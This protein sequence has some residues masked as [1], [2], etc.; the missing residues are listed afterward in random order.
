MT[1]SAEVQATQTAA[2]PTAKQLA[3]TTAAAVL[4]A[5]AI[6]VTIVL[7]AEYGL[8][9]LGTGDRLG[10]TVMSAPQSAAPAALPAGATAVKPVQQ[11][12]LGQYGSGYKVD[13]AQFTLGPYEYVEYKYH[14]EAGASM[15]YSWKASAPLVHDM[16]GELDGHPDQVTSFDKS[17][18][19]EGHGAFVAPFSGIHGWFWENPGGEPVTI[20]V[21]S[22]GFYASALEFRSDKT[23]VPHEL[24]AP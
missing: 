16:H 6:L 10:L 23:R 11:G 9:P 19:Q 5:A 17:N 2:L 8:D 7:P 3:A 1:K 14:L 13:S 22:S 15:L 20:T 18:R 24:S 12:P 4:V 21:T